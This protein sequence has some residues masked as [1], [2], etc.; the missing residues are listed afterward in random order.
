MGAVTAP[1]LIGEGLETCL[2]VMQAT[3][4]TAW[5]ALSTSGLR[6]LD[7]SQELNDIIIIADGDDPGRKAAAAAAQ[8]WRRR[9]RRLR[10]AFAPDGIDFNDLLGSGGG[11]E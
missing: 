8:R 2:S 7:L 10:I 1:L 11:I 5:A 6:T 4:L 3:G 9:D